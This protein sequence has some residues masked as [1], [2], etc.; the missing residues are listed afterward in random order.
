MDFAGEGGLLASCF[1]QPT[2]R[3]LQMKTNLYI[4]FVDLTK[5]FN[6]GIVRLYGKL[7]RNGLSIQVH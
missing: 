1:S 5:G 2:D 7:W 3:K 4:V 6:S